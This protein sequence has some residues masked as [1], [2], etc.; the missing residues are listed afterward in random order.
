MYYSY[1][2]I[3]VRYSTRERRRAPDIMLVSVVDQK[4]PR[5]RT[6]DTLF[7]VL[8]CK[9]FNVSVPMCLKMAHPRSPILHRPSSS[10]DCSVC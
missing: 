10:C 5:F 3:G 9:E 2:M 1:E 4:G 8:F 6:L 7:I